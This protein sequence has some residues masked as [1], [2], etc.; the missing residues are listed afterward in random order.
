M[1]R[2]EVLHWLEAHRELVHGPPGAVLAE[3]EQE[4]RRHTREDA[5]L[6][7]KA[8]ADRQ[9]ER[10]DGSWGFHAS[11]DFVA[12]EVCHQL[13]A[14]LRRLEPQPLDGDEERLAGEH[15]VAILESEALDQLR[16]YLHEL[17]AN[18]E[19]Q[20]WKEVLRFTGH[21][22]RDLV[23]EGRVSRERSWDSTRSYAITAATVT[24]ILSQDFEAH[25]R[26]PD[27]GPLSAEFGS[28]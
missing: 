9:T 27:F 14:Q 15:A 21:R 24:R 16:P 10:W 26:E 19:H 4:V 17:A 25:A 11:E 28:D 3:C 12:E 8:I 2:R 1:E 7:A 6:H 18:A 5:W 23:R 13:A 20:T 22:G